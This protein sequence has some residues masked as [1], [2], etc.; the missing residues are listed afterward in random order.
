VVL[1]PAVVGTSGRLM[2]VEQDSDDSGEIKLS[3]STLAAL[4][5]FYA[6]QNAREHCLVQDADHCQLDNNTSQVVMP[7]EDWVTGLHLYYNRRHNMI[8]EQL[9]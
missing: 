4:Q 2:D 8:R 1:I 7:A 6:E 5:D 3:A 9:S